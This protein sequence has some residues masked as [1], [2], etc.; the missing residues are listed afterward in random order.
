MRGR[1]PANATANADS[2]ASA[3]EFD[4]HDNPLTE[5]FF[6]D[7]L[8]SVSS[9]GISSRMIA[10][11]VGE[12]PLIVREKQ[13]TDPLISLVVGYTHHH[14]SPGIPEIALEGQP[15]GKGGPT[16]HGH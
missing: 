10:I 4:P 2:A 7:P 1:P 3:E 6:V 14:T 16:E 11:V 15:A 12:S 5:G 8:I 13:S 9:P